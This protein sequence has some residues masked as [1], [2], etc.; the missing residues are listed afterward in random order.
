MR[1]GVKRGPWARFYTSEDLHHF[2]LKTLQ[3]SVISN[4]YWNLTLA[5]LKCPILIL[6]GAL[7]QNIQRCQLGFQVVGERNQC[8]SGCFQLRA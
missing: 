5:E 2:A 6:Q 1:N 8:S 3:W 7:T 4:R